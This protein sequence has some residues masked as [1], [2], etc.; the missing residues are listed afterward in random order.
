MFLNGKKYLIVEMGIDSPFSPNNMEYLLTVVKPQIAVFLNAHPTHAQEFDP[1]VDPSI[2]GKK[3]VELLT[4]KIA[5]EKVKIIT[6]SGCKVAIYNGENPFVKRVVEPFRENHNETTFLSFCDSDKNSLSFSSYV[7]SLDSTTFKFLDKDEEVVVT[8]PSYALPQEYAE[9]FSATLL[10]AQTAGVSFSDAVHSLE[11]N[12]SLPPG[13][14]SLLKGIHGS[15]IIDSSYNASKAAV[16]AFLEMVYQLKH[17]RASP[18]VFLFGDMRELG[19]SSQIEHEEVAEKI[20]QGIDY[21]YCIGPDT[22]SYVLPKV[23]GKIKEVKWFTTSSEAGKYMEEKLPEKSIV[24]VKGSQNT[25]FLEEA[26]K[27]ILANKDDQKRLC[28]QSN[29]WLLKKRTT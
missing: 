20:L 23:E 22:K 17:E 5:E 6:Q 15:T 9:V 25:I 29:Y 2:T 21:L 16:I 7:L 19:T 28:R 11:K 27:Y 10:V 14:A 13:R 24:L 3:R 4:Q 26:V 8:V 1:L 12:F 18:T